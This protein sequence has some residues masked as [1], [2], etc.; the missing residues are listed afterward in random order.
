MGRHPIVLAELLVIVLLVRQTCIP[1]ERT[2]GWGWLLRLGLFAVPIGVLFNALTVHAGDNVLV[3]VPDG[4]PLIGGAIT[5]N[6]VA[7]GALSGMTVVALVATGTTVA[8][9]IDWSALMRL[10]PP[11]AASM[12]V[13]GSVAWSFLPQLATSWREIRE[14]QAARGHR[15]RGAKDIVPLAVPLLAGGLERSVTMAEALESRG[16]GVA[17]ASSRASSRRSIALAMAITAAVVAIYLLAV[18]EAG[19]AAGTLAV[20]LLVAGIAIRDG[21]RRDAARAT[22]FREPRWGTADTLVI[23]AAATAALVTTIALQARPEALRYDP[24]P[25]LG[26]PVVSTWLLA[27]LALLSVPIVVAPVPAASSGVPT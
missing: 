10:V 6:G 24:Y 4:V 22:R 8:G 9:A 11:R 15:F 19:P 23:S 20:S 18:G 3:R 14:A 26:W 2:G 7:Y 27:A 21:S 5:A 25:T 13:A 16:F 12:A 17:A 1:P